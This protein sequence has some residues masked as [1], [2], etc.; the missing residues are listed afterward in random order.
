MVI[1]R[2]TSAV[3]AG[4]LAIALGGGL[5]LLVATPAQAFDC[6]QGGGL[7]SGITSN[8]CSVVG[9]VGQVVDSVTDMADKATGGATA[10]LTKAVDD[11]VK[12]T[13]STAGTAVDD[14]GHAVDDTVKTTTSTAGTAVNDVGHAVDDT[15]TGLTGT[16]G[17]TVAGTTNTVKDVAGAAIATATGTKTDLKAGAT[18]TP[19]AER[20]TE[21]LTGTVQGTC[22][23]LVGGAQCAAG[24]E[25]RS[26]AGEESSPALQAPSQVRGTLPRE[27]YR[28]STRPDYVPVSD[29]SSSMDVR[30]NPDEDG[31]IPLLWP[32]RM[33][34]L[35]S[36]MWGG[37][38]VVRPQK[39][40]DGPGTAL[41][42]VLLLS[43][44][45]ATRVV[46]ARRARG[47][48]QE[49]IPFEGGLRVP[50]RSGRHR[51]A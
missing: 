8:L 40:Y 2:K 18:P 22:L 49:S 32:G 47:E 27:P 20:L 43:A 30:V 21:G 12:T 25:K 38:P 44:V 26:T 19:I 42:A 50:S 35:T 9:G 51:L 14:V 36:Q 11:T 3:S 17:T 1:G 16:V 31:R 28:P 6:T 10:P 45:L 23:P 46:A 34:E 41:T 48:Q 29:G 15:G 24:E 33:P 5:P 4:V 37:G 13:T 7:I 39:T